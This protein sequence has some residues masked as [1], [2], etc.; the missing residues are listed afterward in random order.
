MA[1]FIPP[2]SRATDAN[3]NAL[4]GAVWHFYTTGTTN[5]AAVYTSAALNVA[6]GP[7]VTA[8][9]GGKFPNIFLDPAVTYRAILKTAGGSVL[10]DVDPY[11]KAVGQGD[12]SASAGSGLVG[13]IAA[14]ADAVARSVQAKLRE[15]VSVK[16]FGALGNGS[17]VDT[18]AINAAIA[19]LTAGQTLYFPAG[20]YL[21]DNSDLQETAGGTVSTVPL[22]DG[23]NLLMEGGAWL[24]RAPADTGGPIFITATGNNIIQANIDGD[25]FPLTGG[26]S[27]T[28]RTAGGVGISAASASNVTLI[29]CRF[30]NLTYGVEAIGLTH[31][32]ILNSE[33]YRIKLSGCLLRGNDAIGAAHNLVA[34]CYFESMGDTA[35]ALHYV[36]SSSVVAYNTIALCHAKDTQM[37]ED[38][39]AFDIEAS[40]MPGTHHHNRF[41]DLTVEQ[42]TDSGKVQ[43]GATM[44]ANITDSAITNCILKGNGT[45][46]SYGVSITSTTDVRVTNN[47]IEGFRGGAIY[48]DGAIRPLIDGNQIKDCGDS[49]SIINNTILLSAFLGNTAPMVTGNRITYSAGYA[50]AGASLAAI[51]GRYF[52]ALIPDDAVVRGN[53]IE[54]PA[55]IAVSFF[56][57]SGAAK[58]GTLYVEGNYAFGVTAAPFQVNW[59]T[60]G[61]IQGNRT[62]VGSGFNLA[63]VAAATIIRDN[64]SH[65]TEAWGTSAAIASGSTIAH[66]L[67][68]TPT[69]YRATPTS[70][71]ATDV[72]I[73][74]DATN[75]TVNFGGGGSHAF[76][77]EA[78]A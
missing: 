49:G 19:S 75:L 71:G 2:N 74:A 11:D 25:E 4:S 59:N 20:I 57:F 77:W 44:N 40:V 29:N 27:G 62:D 7:S 69:S 32:K 63:N 34:I 13:H 45:I 35:V 31:W 9:A 64:D 54:G 22:P 30:R 66:G 8:D 33:F 76:S 50:G 65:K 70:T 26:I 52:N 48:A 28:W 43:G 5:P 55:G 78:R 14:G 1:L 72:W 16:D 36:T 68:V 56:G 17:T 18:L 37:R 12:L 60:G 15:F 47:L 23:A 3:A 61:R 42:V 58:V 21:V 41:A 73:T 53:L 10:L 67:A 24:K 46:E 6:H 38:G 51:S 39:Y